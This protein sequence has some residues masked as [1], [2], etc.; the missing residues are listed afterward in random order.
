MQEEERALLNQASSIERSQDDI[1]LAINRLLWGRAETSASDLEDE[2]TES[3][4]ADP[5]R[6]CPSD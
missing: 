5:C 2:D 6:V 1:M 3:R 4:A